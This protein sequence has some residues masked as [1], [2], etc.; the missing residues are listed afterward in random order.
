MSVISRIYFTGS[1]AIRPPRQLRYWESRT[2]RNYT[3]KFPGAQDDKAV[4]SRAPANTVLAELLSSKIYFEAWMSS[5]IIEECA[6][7]Y[8]TPM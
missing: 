4:S 2:F 1:G 7:G 8:F 6:K 5:K 3:F